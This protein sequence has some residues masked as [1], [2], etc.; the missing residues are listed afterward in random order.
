MEVAL[1]RGSA[2]FCRGCPAERR[3]PK[4]IDRIEPFGFHGCG[5]KLNRRACAG[6]GPCFHVPG[7]YCGYRFLSHS[8]ISSRISNG[9]PA[10]AR[11]VQILFW[12]SESTVFGDLDVCFMFLA[13]QEGQW[14]SELVPNGVGRFKCGQVDEIDALGTVSCP[15]HFLHKESS[16]LTEGPCYGGPLE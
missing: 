8:H 3:C 12:A 15:H 13:C 4:R 6:F 10:I 11:Y 9:A 16:S 1:C 5:S 2:R 7:L 14:N